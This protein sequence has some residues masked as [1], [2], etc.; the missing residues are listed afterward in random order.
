MK[1]IMVDMETL[2]QHAGCSILSIGAVEFDGESGSIGETFYITIS[3]SSC[4]LEGLKED[5]ETIK[6]WENQSED[7]RD[8]AFNHLGLSLRDTLNHFSNWVMQFGDD[9]EIW[10]N[11]SDFDNAILQYAYNLLDM[12][13]PWKFYNNRCYRTLKNLF[14]EVALVR[15]GTHHDAL[16]DAKSQA[17]HAVAILKFAK[18]NFIK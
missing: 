17:E 9:V 11:G 1:K 3:R 14:P 7:A 12:K 8:K 15:H 4:R 2:G 10:G 16:D 13:Q 5:P 6:W 18:T